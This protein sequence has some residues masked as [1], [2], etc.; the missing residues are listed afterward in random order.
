MSNEFSKSARRQE[1]VSTITGL[2]QNLGKLAPHPNK[3]NDASPLYLNSHAAFNMANDSDG[4]LGTM[5]LEGMLGTAFFVAANDITDE[6]SHDL[7]L[8]NTADCISEYIKDTEGK[9]Q[10]VAAHGQGTMARIAGRSI[11]KGFNIHS[12]EETA[13]NNFMD[14][15][16]KRLLIERNLAHYARELDLINS[17]SYRYAA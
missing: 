3:S 1:I 13:M 5:V 11:S 14:D 7:D 4:M 17:S 8:G 16:E 2:M 12:Q 15:L 6:W 9:A 10:K